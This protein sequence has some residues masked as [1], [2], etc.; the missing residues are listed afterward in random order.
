[1]Y[2][3][4]TNII[5]LIVVNNLFTQPLAPFLEQEVSESLLFENN[6]NETCC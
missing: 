6:I 3:K 2:H 4:D 5:L 1:M